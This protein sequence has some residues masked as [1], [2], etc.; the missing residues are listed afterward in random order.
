[1]L[2][3]EEAGRDPGGRK[4]RRVLLASLFTTVAFAAGGLLGA[5]WLGTDEVLRQERG[6]ALV[7]ETLSALGAFPF[8]QVAALDG[9]V[10][11][12][13]G[14]P[15]RAEL[16]VDLAVKPAK[17]GVLEITAKLMDNRTSRE[18]SRQVTYRGRG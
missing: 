8:D 9:S 7:Q 3:P 1:M 6:A 14:D 18:L 17:E 13:N 12:E 5:R 11:P 15:E 16:R 4:L 2:L 10:L